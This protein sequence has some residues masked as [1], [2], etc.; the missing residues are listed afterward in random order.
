MIDNIIKFFRR[1]RVLLPMEECLLSCF[2][3]TAGDVG[4]EL[5]LAQIKE[6]RSAI[7]STD[8]NIVKIQYGSNRGALEEKIGFP[9]LQKQSVIG[10]LKF[11]DEKGNSNVIQIIQIDGLISFFEYILPI[12]N[13][14]YGNNV[15]VECCDV[16]LKCRIEVDWKII[17]RGIRSIILLEGLDLCKIREAAL[18]EELL[19]AEICFPQFPKDYFKLCSVC[20]GFSVA[21]WDFLG[22]RFR[23]VALDESRDNYGFIL[24]ENMF[25]YCI[26]L[27][28]IRA[29]E[30]ML[31]LS[32]IDIENM[33]I[34][35]IEPLSQN[36]IDAF[37][38]VLDMK[39]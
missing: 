17:T 13:Y 23:R 22:L 20:D 2:A 37:L 28:N 7:R 18:P 24:A 21:S 16:Y 8:E 38:K 29:D 11:Y 26:L 19:G 32:K 14:I 6:I 9:L 31:F 4:G 27:K 5:I 35:D 10:R 1:K 33:E 12:K 34:I 25:R 15:D 3:N 36:F 30:W 39:I